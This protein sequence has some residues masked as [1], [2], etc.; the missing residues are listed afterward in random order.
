[1]TVY[2]TFCPMTLTSNSVR[3]KSSPTSTTLN[4]FISSRYSICLSVAERISQARS[5]GTLNMTAAAM[6]ECPSGV[7]SGEEVITTSPAWSFFICS[8][9]KPFKPSGPKS[10]IWYSCLCPELAGKKYK[11][12]K[13]NKKTDKKKMK[14]ILPEPHQV[15]LCLFSFSF[16]G[17]PNFKSLVITFRIRPRRLFL[18]SC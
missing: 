12:E 1:M 17:Q 14:Q 13:A 2:L 11:T 10:G 5:T 16:K 7:T 6:T 3:L 15:Y 9:D 18:T 4:F 8:G